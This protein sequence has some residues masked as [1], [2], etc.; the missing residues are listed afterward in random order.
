MED[1]SEDNQREPVKRRAVLLGSVL[2]LSL[3]L[4]WCQWRAHA[5]LQDCVTV[6][7]TQLTRMQSDAARIQAL[8]A[9]PKLAAGRARSQRALLDQIQRALSSA[10]I[11]QQQ[12]QSS[13]PLT[14]A[15]VLDSDYVKHTTQL[16]LEKV[17][18]RKLAT[19][20]HGLSS[21]DP[22]LSVTAIDLIRRASGDSRFDVEVAVSHL[23]Y[24]P[25]G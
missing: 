4:A 16:S 21:R 22:A 7:R 12:W 10:D 23:V 11:D 18:L 1:R 15:R 2:T 19:F 17:E 25:S 6:A 13:T 14:P 5:S 20:I 9:A 3:M 8:S 24:A